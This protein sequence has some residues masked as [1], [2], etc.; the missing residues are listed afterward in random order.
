MATID[1]NSGN[2]PVSFF[3][4]N[5]SSPVRFCDNNASGIQIATKG[6][7]PKNNTVQ[8]GHATSLLEINSSITQFNASSMIQ[9]GNLN[10][11]ESVLTLVDSSQIRTY[12]PLSQS[13]MNHREFNVSGSSNKITLSENG[14]SASSIVLDVNSGHLNVRGSSIL[15][16][17]S[18]GLDNQYLTVH[19][20]GTPYKIALHKA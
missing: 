15:S 7:I 10:G 3:P 16:Q 18:N 17:S 1:Y 4:S 11:A 6:A 2:G 14:L 20:N 9:M 8:I 13:L 12:G 19:L 5:V